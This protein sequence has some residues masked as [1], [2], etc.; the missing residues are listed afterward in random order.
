MSKLELIKLQELLVPD[1]LAVMNKRLMIL[2]RIYYLQPIG[3]RGLTEHLHLTERVLRTEVEFLKKQGLITIETAG[4]KTTK[5]GEELLD[6]LYPFMSQ[7]YGFND[8]EILLQKKFKL[9]Q[10]YVVKGDADQDQVIKRTIGSVAAQVLISLLKDGDILAL[11]GGTT[12]AEMVDAFPKDH[13]YE[14]VTIVPARGGMDD[15]IEYQAN[16]LVGRLAQKINAT[17]RLFHLPAQISS[18][19]T[20]QLLLKDEQIIKMLAELKKACIVVHGIGDAIIMAQ[21]RGV[22]N[23]LL[24]ELKEKEAVG[25]AF[26]YYFNIDGEIV[27]KMNVVGLTIEDLENVDT[28]IAIAGGSSKAKA[29]LAVLKQK[30]IDIL[31]I[32]EAIAKKLLN[33]V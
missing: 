24:K 4:M 9:K 15:D 16:N 30:I 3:R 33:Q 22:S 19:D 12:V 13:S 6:K 5:M 1:L 8:L 10:V 25:E 31:I 28:V 29:V 27:Y 7:L 20:Y 11:T 21:K 23:E 14:Q 26:G 18:I 32:D 17:Y 2:E